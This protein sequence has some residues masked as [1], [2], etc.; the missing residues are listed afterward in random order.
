MAKTNSEVAEA[1][2]TG[3]RPCKGSN[4]EYGRVLVLRKGNADSEVRTFT[5]YST[6]VAV[7]RDD[8][9]WWRDYRSQS[10]QRQLQYVR[11]AWH[12]AKGDEGKTVCVPDPAGGASH[13][14]VH[15]YVVMGEEA[16][17]ALLKPRIRNTTKVKHW[18][19]FLSWVER[20]EHLLT[21]PC[22][23]LPLGELVRERLDS[24]R[25]IRDSNDANPVGLGTVITNIR[26]IHAL[27]G[28]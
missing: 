27:E 3:G 6:V 17:Q 12:A 2:A 8:I 28:K 19:E 25:R 22:Y 5:S 13:T 4:T 23:S 26:A 21:M 11:R 18:G 1:F 14:N 16:L 24:L 15:A 10:T 7:I 9:L 20:T